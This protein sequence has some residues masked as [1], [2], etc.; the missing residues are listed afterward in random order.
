MGHLT[1]ERKR[2]LRSLLLSACVLAA[3]TGGAWAQDACLADTEAPIPDDVAAAVA[4]LPEANRPAFQGYQI[5]VVESPY[6]DFKAENEGPWTI[7][8][9]N[10]F[11]GNA[12]RAAALASLEADVE[13]FKAAGLVDDLIVTDSN[14]N[15][16]TQI[17]QMRSMIQ[18]GVDLIISIPGSPTAMDAVI[19]E[20]FDAGI[21]VVTLAAPVTSPYALNVDTNGFL[22]GKTMATGLVQL[23]G[24]KGTIMT[25]QGIP[26]TSGSEMIAAGGASVFANCPDINIIAD[27]VGQWSNSVAKTAMLQALST[28][29][30]PIDAVWQQGSMFMGITQAIEQA[31]RPLVPVTIGNPDQNALAFWHDKM[32]EGY[33]TV[34]TANAP[35]AGMDLVFR[36]GIRTLMGQGPKISGIVVRPPLITADTLEG[37]WKPEYTQESTG[38]GEPPPGTWMSDEV[39]DGYFNNPAPLP[40]Q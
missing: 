24:G 1:P 31:G 9:N 40:V 35:G 3:G 15:I 11:S 4:L 2:S 20:A 29:P 21:P 6:A 22:L 19:K 28:N 39:L 36:V 30:A 23:L 37:W 16:S 32:A 33:K 27:L 8:Y 5:P 14:G 26:G 13:K 18:Q 7:G 17:Q 25:V 38:V 34:G 10:S 12:W